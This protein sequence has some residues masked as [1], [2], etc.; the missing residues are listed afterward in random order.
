MKPDSY[1]HGYSSIEEQRLL[2]QSSTLTEL[3]HHDTAY[4][5]GSTVLEAGC[6]VGAQTTTLAHRSPA[7]HFVSVDISPPSLAA[8][9]QRLKA[10]RIANVT[11]V[12][13]DLL[14]L[15][16]A[17]ASFDH[18][19]VCFVLEHLPRVADA[20]AELHRVLKPG[21]T[22]TVIEGDHGSAFFHPDSALAR[23]AIACLIE[24]QARS[25]GDALIGRRIGS[26]LHVGGF[27]DITVSPRFVHADVRHP[28]LI[29]G[30][31]LDTFTAMVA[32]VRE[33]VLAAGLMTE[34]D[35]D[36]AIAD[37]HRTAQP[38]GTFC[39]CFFKAVARRPA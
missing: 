8:T 9:R 4:P 36:R 19:F 37:L 26:V 34:P 18:V 29:Q 14:A 2:A 17:D 24:L 12:Q 39:Y 38:D 28:E 6:G 25:G 35:W 10:A 15:P 31:T 33:G 23:R 22:I 13:A 1:V 27:A 21:G 32:G 5:A 16:F 3:L 20:L 7:A 30:F 11:L